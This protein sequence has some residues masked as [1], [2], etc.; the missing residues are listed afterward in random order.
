MLIPPLLSMRNNSKKYY[1]QNGFVYLDT[2][3]LSLYIKDIREIITKAYSKNIDFYLR[4]KHDLYHKRNA[5]VLD[6]INKEIDTKSFRN[7]AAQVISENLGI[8]NKFLTSSFISYLATRPSNQGKKIHADH[9]FVDFHRE[10][11]YTDHGYANHQINVWI[12]VFDVKFL[13]NFKYVPNSHLIKDKD[14]IVKRE[15]NKFIKKHS[16]AHKCGL[17]YAPKRIISGVNLKKAKRFKVP[18]NKFL[19]LNAN[20]I[21]G[22]GINL[23]NKIRFAISFSLIEDVYFKGIKIP[24]NF[25]SKKPHFISL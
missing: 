4:E 22:G 21:H 24:V 10:N 7:T 11:F 1:N 18:N 23:T 25:R 16:Y 13:Q 14:I 15:N 19:I 9:E 20:L 17:N 12:P 8:K 5:K 6:Q 3:K 2:A